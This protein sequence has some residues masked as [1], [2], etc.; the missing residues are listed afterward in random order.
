MVAVSD[1]GGGIPAAIR[2]KVFEPFFTTKDTG[3]GTGLGLSMVYGF[4]KQS[5]GHL[6][7]YSEEGHGTSIKLY[8]PRSMGDMV[9]VEPPPAVDT[10]GGHESILVVEDDPLVRNYVSAQLEQ[11]GYRT[12]VTANGPE[13]LAA[14]EKGFVCDVLFT[15][16]IMS[17]GMNGRQVADAV[18][19]KLPSVRVL[20]TSG[21]TEDAIIH[22]GRLDPDVTL[23][24]KPYRKADLARMIRQVLTQP[25]AAAVAA[26]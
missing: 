10:R 5:D 21:Y 11:L 20:L 24:P 19:A 16:V 2:D 7:I 23:L 25:P 22:H 15:D 18:T 3:K 6:K 14:V 26:K 8:L 13:A 12:M 1:T 9:D 17:G 4:I